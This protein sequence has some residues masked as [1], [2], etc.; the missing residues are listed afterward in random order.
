MRKADSHR[1]DHEKLADKKVELAEEREKEG[2]ALLD[3]S[4]VLRF[5]DCLSCAAMGIF[6]I[7]CHSP[8][9]QGQKQI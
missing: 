8:F 9:Q 1:E 2:E 3:T 5:F 4:S 7:P 6:M